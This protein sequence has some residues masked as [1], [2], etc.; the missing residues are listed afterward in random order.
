MLLCQRKEVHVNI[1]TNW[2]NLKSKFGNTLPLNS[3][4]NA[5]SRETTFRYKLL[6]PC[7]PTNRNQTCQTPFEIER[8]LKLVITITSPNLHIT[9]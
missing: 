2:Q 5:G 7:I 8:V 6:T 4:S 3:I 9:I 1:P